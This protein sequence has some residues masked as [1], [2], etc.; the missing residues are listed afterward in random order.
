[1][2]PREFV[3]TPPGHIPMVLLTP[4]QYQTLNAGIQRP[5][6]FTYTLMTAAAQGVQEFVQKVIQ[7]VVID[8]RKTE[9]P[10]IANYPMALSYQAK[11]LSLQDLSQLVLKTLGEQ[12]L[13]LLDA[14][15]AGIGAGMGSSIA[16]WGEQFMNTGQLVYAYS[17]LQYQASVIPRMRRYWMRE[18]TP[19]VPD[20]SMAW[21]LR[22]RGLITDMQFDVYASYD[23][24]DKAS[25]DLLRNV[26]R[27][28]PNVQAA[29]RMF[30]RGAINDK[31]LH[32]IYY[33]NSWEKEY[34]DALTAIYEWLPNAR[35]AFKLFKRG[36]I[37]QNLM[38]GLFSSQGYMS[39]W[40]SFLPKMWERIP[41]PRDAFNMFMR[42]AIK[43]SDFDKYVEANEW[44]NGSADKLAAIFQ[45][46]PEERQAFTLWKRGAISEA[47]MKALF[48]ADG[49]MPTYDTLLPKLF[50]RIPH[51]RDAFNAL[52]RGVIDKKKF[53][54]WIQANEWQNGMADFLFDIYTRL[55]S[56]HEAFYMWAKGIIDLAQRDELYKANGYDSE[57]H[58]KLT[59]NYYYVPTVY[60]LTRIAD[61]VEIDSIWATRT[62]KERGLRD[63]DISKIIAMLK[64]RP[65]RDEIRRQLVIWV[66][67]YRLGWVT[68]TQLDAALEYYLDNGWIQATE[69]DMLKEEAE[70]NY[71]DE[72]MEEQIDIFSWYFRTAIISEED[73]L[74]DFLALGIR[75]EKAN[76]MVE[77]LKAQG[78]YGYY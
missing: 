45:D 8:K 54:F 29:F 6:Y 10:Y 35:E 65:L 38:Q 33:A 63:R 44:E 42:G 11:A 31:Q 2:C 43:R 26:W 27:Q 34:F 25:A 28:I 61:Y 78:Y 24:W 59:E 60:D 73:L 15:K 74:A 16:Q 32:D 75:E 76:L 41:M 19:A 68:P 51:P 36:H 56:N 9:L 39:R 72:L 20:A 46:L 50:E 3:G 1:M 5:S 48:R 70:I 66:K 55:P 14:W 17:T 21:I 57:W 23:G 69:K 64:I 67:R 30:A 62:L 49:Y 7:G 77:L 22:R 71:E 4:E 47:D 12:T 53:D 13:T 52:M 18:Y 58:A 40:W 37:D